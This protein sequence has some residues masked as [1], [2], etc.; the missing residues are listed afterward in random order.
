MVTYVK[1]PELCCTQRR[2]IVFDVGQ[3]LYLAQPTYLPVPANANRVAAMR[4][5]WSAG[6]RKKELIVAPNVSPPG[7]PAASRSPQVCV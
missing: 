2:K 4:T 1:K 5:P 3:L 7:G 6:P